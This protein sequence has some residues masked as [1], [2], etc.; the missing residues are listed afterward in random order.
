MSQTSYTQ[1][2]SANK[3]FLFFGFVAGFGSSF[4]Q[5]FFI[6]LFGP[7]LQA[8]FDL[9]HTAWGSI[10]LAGTLASA[11]VLP[12]TGKLI[13]RVE[14]RRYTTLVLLCGVAACFYFSLVNGPIMLIIGIFLLRQ[15]GQGLTSHISMTSMARYFDKQRGRAIA[16]ATSGFA[17]GEALLPLTVVLL[18][19][20]FGWRITYVGV[21]IVLF[22]VGLPLV[23]WLL[24]DHAARDRQQAQ[25]AAAITTDAERAALQ[26]SWSRSEVLR[27][28]R[29][30]LLVPAVSSLSVIGTAMFF[31]HLNLAD[32]KGWSHE[33][34]TGNYVVYSAATTVTALVS[35]TWVDRVGATKLVPLMPIPILIALVIVATFDSPYTVWFYFVAM[36]L[37]T[38]LYFTSV[39]AM[40][41]E[42]YG[43]GYIGAIKAMV[44]SIGV[45]GSA[46]G[47]VILG[48]LMD[49][50][51]HITDVCMLFAAFAGAGS[52]LAYTGIRRPAA[53]SSLLSGT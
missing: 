43:V 50:G 39:T 53:Q 27:D 14:L 19:V 12:W 4:G 8:E 42:L 3:R 20:N 38:G 17:C 44:T 35:G 24:H 2:L 26:R 45:F 22:V 41:A 13:D 34:V 32:A 5:T 47:P 51:L 37:S 30:Y 15:T 36:G 49:L 16:V 33:W 10:Y 6:G 52:L 9:S 23:R 25:A 11:T 28:V 1:F 7:H 29:F 18:I 40:W 21:A 48:A 31:H 46:V